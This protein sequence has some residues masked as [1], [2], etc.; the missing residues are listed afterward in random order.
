MR[1]NRGP[2]GQAQVWGIDLDSDGTRALVANQSSVL[3]VWDLES[4][5][6]IR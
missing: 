4:G 3:E 2:W 1:E 6:E 5:R